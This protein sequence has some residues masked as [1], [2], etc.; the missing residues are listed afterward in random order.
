[1]QKRATHPV[2]LHA[3]EKY[4]K[5]ETINRQDDYETSKKWTDKNKTKLSLKVFKF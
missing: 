5:V 3:V 1:M 4:K 2:C